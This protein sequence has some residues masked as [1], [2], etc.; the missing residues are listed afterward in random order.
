MLS[1]LYCH[2]IVLHPPVDAVS[3]HPEAD[4]LITRDSP[5][6]GELLGKDAG[7]LCA[8]L[9][10]SI[11]TTLDTEVPIT[12]LVSMFP[13]LSTMATTVFVVQVL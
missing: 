3:G 4:H 6:A 7:L 5:A 10:V 1:Y 13:S 9:L 12:A 11:L 2:D 8:P